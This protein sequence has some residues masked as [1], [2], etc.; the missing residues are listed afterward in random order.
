MV[1][2]LSSQAKALIDLKAKR[3]HKEPKDVINIC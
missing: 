3:L 1:Q 2:Y